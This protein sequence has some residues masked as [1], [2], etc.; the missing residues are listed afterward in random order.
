MSDM[1]FSEEQI[2]EA[3]SDS[4]KR[5]FFNREPIHLYPRGYAKKDEHGNI[6]EFGIVSFDIVSV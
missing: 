4:V 3:L 5:E 1:K 6:S 2:L